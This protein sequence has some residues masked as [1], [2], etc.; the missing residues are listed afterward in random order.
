MFNI[1]EGTSSGLFFRAISGSANTNWRAVAVNQTTQS[2][3][4]TGKSFSGSYSHLF[5]TQQ[6][7]TQSF[8][9]DNTLVATFT[10][11][12]TTPFTCNTLMNNKCADS[13]GS[14]LSVR[15]IHINYSY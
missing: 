6:N 11:S 14:T 4:D 5:I 2:I 10:Q 9:I 12:F 7:S 8:Y 15:A 3:I 1:N 13:E